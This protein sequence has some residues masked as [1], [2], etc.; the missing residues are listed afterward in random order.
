MG[1]GDS[2]AADLSLSSYGFELPESAIAQRPVEPRHAARLLAVEPIGSSG[3]LARGLTVWDLQHELEPGDLLVVNDTRVLQ[4]R[5]SARRASGGVVELLVLQPWHQRSIGEG[6]DSCWLCLARPAKRLRPGEVLQLE[7]AGQ[8]P[9]AAGGGGGRG[10]WRPGGPLSA[11]VHQRRAD[12]RAAGA[13]RHHAAAPY[14]HEHDAADQTRY[15]TRYAARPGAVAAPPPAC[16]SAMSCWRP[17]R[18]RG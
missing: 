13:L 16:T 3:P 11:G 2:L 1:P 15:Q 18:R 6:E 7:A 8:P 4:A 9:G 12:R 10:Q 14:I 17:W 5:L